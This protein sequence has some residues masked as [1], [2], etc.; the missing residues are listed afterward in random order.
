MIWR[1]PERETEATRPVSRHLNPETDNGSWQ[2]FVGRSLYGTRLAVNVYRRALVGARLT[3]NVYSGALVGARLTV[4]VY[5]GASVD[6]RL[7]VNI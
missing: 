4:N 5:N 1:Y 7:T 3:V 6:A 2:A